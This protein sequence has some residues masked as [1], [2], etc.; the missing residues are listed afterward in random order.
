[1]GFI[2]SAKKCSVDVRNDNFEVLTQKMTKFVC[3]VSVSKRFEQFENHFLQFKSLSAIQITFREI[4]SHSSSLHSPVQV[5]V[6]AWRTFS[7]RNQQWFFLSSSVSSAI[8][9]VFFNIK[10]YAF[11]DCFQ[12][13]S[14]FVLE[15]KRCSNKKENSQKG[16][17]LNLPPPYGREVKTLHTPNISP[18]VLSVF[19][20]IFLDLCTVLCIL[21]S[22]L[23]CQ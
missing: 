21:V 23:R 10:K 3:L 7:G 6:S 2:F 15:V 16:C 12:V 20:A 18:Q 19:P 13:K 22:H 17:L 4:L 1:M 8:Q 14:I 9:A 11:R 5:L